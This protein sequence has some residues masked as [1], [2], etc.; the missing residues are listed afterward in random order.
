MPASIATKAAM[1]L[2]SGISGMKASMLRVYVAAMPRSEPAKEFPYTGQRQS[3]TRI[4][5][6][7]GH[8]PGCV[9]AL[10]IPKKIGRTCLGARAGHE[11][12]ALLHRAL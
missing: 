5:N 1:T 2:P 11:G 8:F 9:V 10:W 3:A 12:E 6:D 7:K 4:C